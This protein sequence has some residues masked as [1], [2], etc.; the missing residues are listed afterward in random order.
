MHELVEDFLTVL[1]GAGIDAPIPDTVGGAL[2]GPN[3]VRSSRGRATIRGGKG[4]ARATQELQPRLGGDW[5]PRSAWQSRHDHT[6]HM[7]NRVIHGGY[8]PIRAEAASAVAAALKLQTWL[9][10]LLWTKRNRYPRVAMTMLGRFG[11]EIRRSLERSDQAVR[12]D[13]SRRRD[14]LGHRFCPLA[15]GARRKH[16]NQGEC[17]TAAWLGPS[18]DA[19]QRSNPRPDP[20]HCRC[21]FRQVVVAEQ[22]RAAVVSLPLESDFGSER[23]SWSSGKDRWCPWPPV[24]DSNWFER[25]S[26]N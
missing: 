20:A 26:T 2:H 25:T 11:L 5:G 16:L 1:Q 24:V 10:D 23:R 3:C 14:A 12:R 18:A 8:I 22:K 13:R 7:R 9:C 21:R 15:R 19:Y 6:A 17:G 4:K